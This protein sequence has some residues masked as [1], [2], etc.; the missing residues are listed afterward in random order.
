LWNQSRAELDEKALDLLPAVAQRIEDFHRVQVR[1]GRK[2]REIVAREARYFDEREQV[3]V[4]E[5]WLR[6]Y[7]RDGRS[8]GVK[9]EEGTV[10]LAGKELDSV[11]LAGD[12]RVTLAD[13]EVR[14][15]YARYDRHRDVISAPAMVSITGGD[16]EAR[17]GGLEVDVRAQRLRLQRDVHMTLGVVK[18]GRRARP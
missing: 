6:V 9:G 11:E 7:L 3:V 14:A 15:E 1:D 2:E 16:I 8:V 13:Y 17:G 12:I 5:P 10:S 18:A 4:R